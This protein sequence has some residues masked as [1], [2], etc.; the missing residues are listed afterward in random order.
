MVMCPVPINSLNN[1][2][3]KETNDATTGLLLFV[4]MYI[5]IASLP[6]YAGQGTFIYY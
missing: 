1:N 3:I 2:I 5:S 4:Y 6:A